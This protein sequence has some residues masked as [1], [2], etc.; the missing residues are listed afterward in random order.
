MQENEKVAKELTDEE[1]MDL[2]G[3]FVAETSLNKVAL[4]MYAV[5]PIFPEFIKRVL[6]LL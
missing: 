5:R 4:L 1:L 2:V 6:G 3:G